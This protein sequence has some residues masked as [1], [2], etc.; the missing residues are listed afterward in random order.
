M[1]VRQIDQ[2]ENEDIEER[3]TTGIADYDKAPYEINRK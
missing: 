3:E 1:G 2:N